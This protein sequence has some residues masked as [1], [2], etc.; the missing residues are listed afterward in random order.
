M[1]QMIRVLTRVRGLNTSNGFNHA[2]HPFVEDPRSQPDSLHCS[3]PC[4]ISRLLEQPPECQGVTPS[5]KEQL[6]VSD[7]RIRITI[8]GYASVELSDTFHAM[9]LQ[10]RVEELQA[11]LHDEEIQ[12]V[13]RNAFTPTSPVIKYMVVQSVLSA[14]RGGVAL[15]KA[16]WK[17]EGGIEG[18]SHEIVEDYWLRLNV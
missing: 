3:K 1:G 4:V 6:S 5:K 10:K 11:L 2:P 8:E 14:L 16:I 13:N 18:V 15:A 17:V 9:P 7:I 12:C